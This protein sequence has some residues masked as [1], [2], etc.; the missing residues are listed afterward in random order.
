MCRKRGDRNPSARGITYGS[1]SLN[2]E[3]ANRGAVVHGVKR[4]DLVDAHGRHLKQTGH[5]I[6]DADAAETVLALA[7]IEQGH[8]GRLL[9]LRGVALDNLFDDLFIVGRELEGDVGVVVGSVAVL[10][11]GEGRLSAR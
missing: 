11:N 6:H 2:V 10:D 3:L 9:V 8:D 1:A 7:K 4:G 5:L